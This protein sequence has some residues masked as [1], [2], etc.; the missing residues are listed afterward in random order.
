MTLSS[1]PAMM[2]IRQPQLSPSL[3]N[4]PP[5]TIVRIFHWLDISKTTY[6]TLIRVCKL[7][8]NAMILIPKSIKIQICVKRTSDIHPALSA[9]ITF[10]SV[11]RACEW[12]SESVPLTLEPNTLTRKTRRSLRMGGCLVDLQEFAVTADPTHLVGYLCQFAQKAI[13]GS[14]E[15]VPCIRCVFSVLDMRSNLETINDDDALLT[16]INV[17]KPK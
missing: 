7:F 9:P 17:C 5:E 6:F 11:N 8:K 2:A 1:S 13:F 14:N 15:E 10:T 4:L 12:N 16:L 3:A